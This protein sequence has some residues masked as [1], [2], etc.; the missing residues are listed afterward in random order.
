M[1]FAF[2]GCKSNPTATVNTTPKNL[3]ENPSFENSGKPSLDSWWLSDTIFSG[4]RRDTLNGADRWVLSL[5]P[6]WVPA[7]AFARTYIMGEPNGIGVYRLT[8]SVRSWVAGLMLLPRASLGKLKNGDLVDFKSFAIGRTEWTKLSI[9]DT[10]SLQQTD[11]LIIQ[12]SSGS[13]EMAFGDTRFD[14]VELIRMN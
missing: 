3:I 6:G 5:A 1:L 11:T 10:L 4:I 8:F 14:D 7:Q 9:S 2:Q 13:V 12:F